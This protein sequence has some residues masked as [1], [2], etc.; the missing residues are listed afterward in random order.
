PIVLVANP[1][2]LSWDQG[3][4]AT[5]PSLPGF[6]HAFGPSSATSP[7]QIADFVSLVYVGADVGS[8]LTYFINDRWGRLWAMRLYAAIWILG[9]LIAVAS[10]GNLSAMY[11]GHIVAGLGIGPLT[12]I[13]PIALTEIAPVETRGLITS[14]FTV[15]LLL[16]LTVAAFVV[17][18]C[19]SLA[20]S[21]LQWRIP[22][23]APTIVTA[24]VIGLSF[25]VQKS[26]RWLFLVGREQE[27]T[28]TLVK[29][30][31]LPLDHPRIQYELQEIWRSGDRSPRSRLSM[32]TPPL[33]PS[34][35]CAP[36]SPSASTCCSSSAST[37]GCPLS[38]RVLTAGVLSCS[39][40][41]GVLWPFSTSSSSSR[42]RRA[43]TSRRSMPSSKVPDGTSTR[44]SR[45]WLAARMSLSPLTL[46]RA[47][48]S[49]IQPTIRSKETDD[50]GY[51]ISRGL[52]SICVCNRKGLRSFDGKRSR[53]G[54]WT[55]DWNADLLLL[56]SPSPGGSP[57]TMPQVTVV[58]RSQICR[59]I[60]SRLVTV[61]KSL[62]Q[63]LLW[64]NRKSGI[65]SSHDLLT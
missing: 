1:L 6:Q 62:T 25:F 39:S 17:L 2:S 53:M 32:A 9:Q 37:R 33:A 11:V 27:S 44:E 63:R 22:F 13:G 38:S 52:F 42:R 55:D 28:D 36:P 12:V 21:N 46:A 57:D 16:S 8:A 19:F 30:R 59:L 40:R 43:W 41:D 34:R 31:G 64:Q 10:S 24:I 50:P 65:A 56:L 26:P 15:V 61:S 3:F 14:C 60:P 20:P 4:S 18:G 48:R 7:K 51:R 49:T 5:I 47:P 35:A 58:I 45:L 54:R 29:L 23:F